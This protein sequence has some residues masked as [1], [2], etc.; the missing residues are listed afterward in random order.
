MG[1]CIFPHLSSQRVAVCTPSYP[2]IGSRYAAPW[3]Q[4]RSGA[5]FT[6]NFQAPL[7]C[8]KIVPA[9]DI[10]CF[11]AYIA[12]L[13]CPSS[14]PP[15]IDPEFDSLPQTTTASHK[16][17]PEPSR[18]GTPSL[19]PPPPAAPPLAGAKTSSPWTGTVR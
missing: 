15:D 2:R 6:F 4:T 9:L 1:P 3:L 17:I 11:I 16:G 13:L 7:S 8:I 19:T 14:K 10:R 18:G 5:P 12:L